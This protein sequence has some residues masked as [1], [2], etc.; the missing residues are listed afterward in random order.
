MESE[1]SLGSLLDGLLK[2]YL[3]L[4]DQYQ[5]LRHSLGRHLSAVSRL[6][7]KLLTCVIRMRAGLLCACA[8]QFF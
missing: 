6:M 1:E 8:S 5:G 3:S 7:V 2:R 4:L